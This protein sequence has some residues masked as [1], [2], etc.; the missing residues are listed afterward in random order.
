MKTMKRFYLFACV[1]MLGA[2]LT[3]A[4]HARAA[5]GSQ[6]AVAPQVFAPGVISGPANDADPTFSSDGNT[7][8]FSR[9]STILSAQHT[10]NG[11]SAP[12]IASFSG[13]WADQQPSMAPDGSFLVF[14]SNR[15]VKPG[16]KMGP[17]GNLWRVD[18][19]GGGWSAP[20]HLPATVN[21]GSST[22]A[23]SVAGDGSLYFIERAAAEAPFRLW[24]SQYRAG[25]YL[26]PV[27]QFFGD[28]RTQDVDP[29]VAPDESFI[30][31]GSML[32]SPNAHERLFIAFRHG[33][34][35]G[36]PIDLGKAVN[37]SGATDT[38]EARLGPDRHTLY[39]S[40]DRSEPIGF[41]RT[42]AQAEADLARIDRWDNGNQNIWSV[43][44]L[45]WLNAARAGGSAP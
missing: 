39:F 8:Y 26:M 14:V 38:N 4:H 3:L 6:Q 9:N 30:V 13:Q 21:R 40:T 29:A 35:W 25:Q 24:R 10:G 1:G 41:P 44:L 18:R 5:D 37:G 19:E 34:G 43:S 31:F 36:A 22:W 15:P 32:P 16:E 27:A 33:E 42:H 11:W 17:A 7:V 20:V 23:P 45:P 2:W 12:R 28:L